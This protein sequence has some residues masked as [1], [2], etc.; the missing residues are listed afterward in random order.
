MDMKTDNN[1]STDLVCFL[2][3][4]HETHFVLYSMSGGGGG[5]W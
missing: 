5:G 4:T 2:E 3:V 1:T